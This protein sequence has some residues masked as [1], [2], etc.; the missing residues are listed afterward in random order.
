[1]RVSRKTVL[2]TGIVLAIGLVLPAAAA[3]V[4][5]GFTPLFNGENL[6]GWDGDPRLWT[7]E[8]SIIRGETTPNT[9]TPV[10]TFLIWRGGTL[11][12]FEL[13]LSA[14]ITTGNSGIQV[15]SRDKGYWRV[16][17]YQVEVAPSAR[18][19]GLWY[20]EMGDR[21]GLA[22]AG[23]RVFIDADGEKKITSIGDPEK[24]QSAYKEGEWNDYTVIGKGNLLSQKIN[25]VVFSEL[26]DEETTRSATSG[27]L[28]LQIH[29]GPPM[30]V[31]FKNVRLRS[32]T[33]PPGKREG[34]TVIL[35]NGQDLTG[36]QVPRISDFS[37]GGKVEVKD[38]AIHLAEGMPMTGVRWTGPF[39]TSNYEVSLEGKRTSG[40]DFFCGMTFP[41]GA[42]WVTLICGG[43]G[44]SVLGLSN[45][46][47]L[48]ASENMSG[49]G[50]AF[51][52]DRWYK[53]RAR[54]TDEKITIW[55]DDEEMID[56]ARKGRKFSVWEEQAPLKPFGIS[57]YQTGGAL[58]NIKLRYL[59][60]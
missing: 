37:W 53:I 32:H 20:D 40:V 16:A 8:D 52:D 10:N 26:I 22:R 11:H 39:P 30:V 12:D 47:D 50:M 36:W 46:D 3:E 45:I 19:Q 2:C 58:R 41:V 49:T 54:V 56:I 48:N 33:P 13:R 17:G 25:G 21:R 38:G 1:M 24:I 29:K 42:S 6:L 60:D 27:V 34:D 57:T 4:E 55:I 51:E 15:R 14:R 35:F 9:P 44:G 28:A 7:I 59:D 31:E 43:W 5:E 23:Q 18:Q